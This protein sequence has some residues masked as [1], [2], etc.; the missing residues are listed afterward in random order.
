[1]LNHESYENQCP[2]KYYDLTALSIHVLLSVYNGTMLH[3]CSV[4]LQH[5]I[6][7]RMSHVSVTHKL[8]VLLKLNKG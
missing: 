2:M 3:K 5:L 6:S 8:H 7:M 4:N 1:M